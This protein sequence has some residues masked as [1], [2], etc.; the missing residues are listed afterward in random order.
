MLTL[1]TTNNSALLRQIANAS[2]ERAHR[3]FDQTACCEFPELAEERWSIPCR[4]KKFAD[5]CLL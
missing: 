4:F 2:F 3:R 1:L 5:L